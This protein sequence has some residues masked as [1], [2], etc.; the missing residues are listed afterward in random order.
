MLC[1]SL[2][3]AVHDFATELSGR[4][5]LYVTLAAMNQI[6]DVIYIVVPVHLHSLQFCI[7]HSSKALSVFFPSL[8]LSKLLPYVNVGETNI[9]AIIFLVSLV[10]FL[11]FL[12]LTQLFFHL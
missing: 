2:Q 7:S 4:V 1:R 8:I 6:A 5:I 12:T 3:L 10:T 9:S 11:F